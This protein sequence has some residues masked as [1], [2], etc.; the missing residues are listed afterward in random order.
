MGMVVLEQIRS[1]SLDKRQCLGVV[2]CK[3]HFI[4]VEH[5]IIEELVFILKVV[6]LLYIHC[7]H[8]FVGMRSK[9]F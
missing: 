2:L 4:V 1:V 7:A 5:F 8:R 6:W 3:I 9:L